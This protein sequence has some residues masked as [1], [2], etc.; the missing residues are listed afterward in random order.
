M[1]RDEAIQWI[2][3]ARGQISRELHNDPDEFVRFHK[4]L[5]S[6]YSGMSKQAQPLEPVQRSASRP[7]APGKR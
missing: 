4:T 7:S 1:R 6:R 2:R 3:D 5:R